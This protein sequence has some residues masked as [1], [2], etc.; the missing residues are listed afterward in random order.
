MFVMKY[1]VGDGRMKQIDN[2]NLI[3]QEE[4]E[5]NINNDEE[6]EEKT[7]YWPYLFLFSIMLFFCI[8]GFTYS[9]YRGSDPSDNEIDIGNIIFTYSDVNQGGNG[10]LIKNAMP[11][12]DSLGK[13]MVGVGQY[14]DFYITANS[15]S[16]D[17]EYKL[18]I[19]KSSESTLKNENVRIYL[20]QVMGVYEK[21]LV[22]TDFSDLKKETISGKEYYV[23]YIKRLESSEETYNDSYRL[24]MWVKETAIDY[25]NQYFSIKV[26]VNASQVEE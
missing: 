10:I 26:D 12:S 8:F 21:E 5:N 3:V 6:K 13:A 19:N 20:T 25:Q 2:E 15:K 4:K 18:L 17:L 16:S 9:I 22:L 14:F 7:S 11:T 1:Y 24:R 23:L